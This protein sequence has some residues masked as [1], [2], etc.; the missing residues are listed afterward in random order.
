MIAFERAVAREACVAR[1]EINNFPDFPTPFGNVPPNL[2][3]DRIGR[4][5]L[6]TIQV[7]ADFFTLA[8][9]SD[10]IVVDTILIVRRPKHASS[11][12]RLVIFEHSAECRRPQLHCSFRKLLTSSIIRIYH[13]VNK[14]LPNSMSTTGTKSTFSLLDDDLT[15]I[16]EIRVKMAKTALLNQS[17]VV[18]A[19]LILLANADTRSAETA[20]KSLTRRKRGRRKGDTQ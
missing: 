20:I 9:R 16:E 18:R 17:E 5:D 12:V 14:V 15:R 4:I 8:Q 6:A 19:G 1:A 10:G 3:N 13:I 2:L 11:P 7:E